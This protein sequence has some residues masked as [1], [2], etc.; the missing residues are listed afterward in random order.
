[1][2]KC[3]IKPYAISYD[4]VEV[5]GAFAT[6]YGITYP[7]LADPDSQAI[8]AFGIFN[9]LIPADHSWYG[10]P[11]PGTY[12]VDA[13]GLVTDKSFYANH[14]VRDG[15]A[16]MLQESF[17]LTPTG[18]PV[19]RLENADI[20]ATATLSSGTIRPG[21]VQ[22]FS[23][24]IQLKQ[25]R[26]IYAPQ[27]TG[28]YKPVELVIDPIDDAQIDPVVYPAPQILSILG[29][30]VPVYTDQLQLKAAVRSHSKADFSIAARL[31]YQA[32]DESECYM[33]QQLAF[34][35]PLTFIDNIWQ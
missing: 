2:Q 28:G 10:V 15:V 14:G 27:V 1:M 31:N 26:H 7:L 19:Q 5:L 35:L 13:Q 32:C 23:L 4:S 12:M 3:G 21:Q 34:A 24:D 6:K 17:H 22:T 16:Q 18:R 29:E 20:T 30:E 25:G 33:P 9:D 8:R 11:F